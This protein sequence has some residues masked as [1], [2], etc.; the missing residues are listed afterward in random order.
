[1]CNKC[2]NIAL[3]T[4]AKRKGAMGRFIHYQKKARVSPF[5]ACFA[6]SAPSEK[7]IKHRG[8]IPR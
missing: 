7:L 1:M 2:H 3:E 5:C 8:I 6:F 4:S